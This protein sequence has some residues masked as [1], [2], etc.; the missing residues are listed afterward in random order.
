MINSAL[1]LTL[2][3][4][5]L[6]VT[7]RFGLNA[8]TLKKVKSTKLRLYVNQYLNPTCILIITQGHNHTWDLARGLP[9]KKGIKKERLATVVATRR[10]IG[11]MSRVGKGRRQRQCS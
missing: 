8:Y 4:L 2:G 10:G 1:A 6:Y 9:A 3:K 11:A 5:H 7:P